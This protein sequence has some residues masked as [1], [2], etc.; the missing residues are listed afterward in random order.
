[1]LA[2]PQSPTRSPHDVPLE[3]PK[4]WLALAVGAL[5]RPPRHQVEELLRGADLDVGLQ[6]DGVIRLHEGVEE[7]VDVDGVAALPPLREVVPLEELSD[8]EVG[9]DL[10][11][12]LEG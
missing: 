8:G 4:L 10:Y 9:G 3:L 12:L 5:Q 1:M 7:L 11:Q 6:C 2:H